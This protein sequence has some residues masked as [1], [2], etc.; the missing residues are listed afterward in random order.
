M[1]DL[2]ISPR[3]NVN[4]RG[5]IQVLPGEVTPVKIIN[6]SSTGIQVQCSAMLQEKLCYELM[7]EVP[8]PRDFARRIQVV[9]KASCIYTVL[10]GNEYRAGMKFFDVP[11]NDRALLAKWHG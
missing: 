8:D 2:R 6:L 9:C 10:S 5:A 3:V 4:W 11:T 7:M 1:S